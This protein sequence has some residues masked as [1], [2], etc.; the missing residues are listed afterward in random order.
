MKVATRGDI[1]QI[2]KRLDAVE[3]QVVTVGNNVRTI[4]VSGSTKERKCKRVKKG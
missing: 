2:D 4:Q 1:A 3:N